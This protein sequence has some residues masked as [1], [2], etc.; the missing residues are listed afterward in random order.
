MSNLLLKTDAY[1]FGGHADQ[2]PQGTNKIYSYMMARS[3]KKYK[4]C[5]FFGLQY[6][7]KKYLKPITQQNVEEAICYYQ[8]IFGQDCPQHIRKRWIDLFLLGYLPLEIKAVS[9]GTVLPVKNVM[10]TI[11]NTHPD[12]YWLVGYVESLLL[13]VWNTI[14][15][16]TFSREIKK[17]CLF[18]LKDTSDNAENLID[19]M[20][21]DFGYRGCSSD[22]T[23]ALSGAAHLVN[24]KGTDTITAVK[25]IADYY[26]NIDQGHTDDSIGMSIPASE[27]S[28]MC[29]YGEENELQ[30]FERMLELYPTGTVSIVSDTYNLWNVMTKFTMKLKDKILA[31]E[32]KVIFRPDSGDPIKI[33]CGDENEEGPARK[34]CLRLLDNVFGHT[35]NAKGYKLLNSKVGLVYGDGMYYE[36]YENMLKTMKEMGYATSNLVIGMGG[37]LL[38]QHNR[39]ELDIAFKATYCEI[40]GLGKNIYKRPVTDKKKNSHKGLMYLTYTREDGFYTKDECSVPEEKTGLLKEIFN[41]NIQFSIKRKEEYLWV[42]PNTQEFYKI[43]IRVG[44]NGY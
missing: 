4:E 30:A 19:Y 22:E 16:A 24:F 33:I 9:E 11:T 44:N 15:V 25:L 35:V 1:K 13:K 3:D 18:Y 37:L 14:T 17:L 12:F 28:V 8:E 32:G 31:R 43:K 41:N 42:Y 23:A 39:D 6:Y 36:R 20:V 7:I 29:A 10:C 21:H 40:N 27:H 26:Q 38:Q 5:V 2:Y 34:G